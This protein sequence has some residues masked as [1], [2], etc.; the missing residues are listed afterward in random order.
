MIRQI[1]IKIHAENPA[2][3]LPTF[4]IEEYSAATFI[5]EGVPGARG[6]FSIDDITAVVTRADATSQ[7]FGAVKS[8]R[9][10][11][12]TVPAEAFGSSGEIIGGVA[13]FAHGR[14]EN[15]A[16]VESW[17]IGNGD[18]QIFAADGS[19]RPGEKRVE[20]HY[21]AEAPARPSEGDI[22]PINGTWSI[23]NGSRWSA[24]GARDYNG[25]ANK[26]KIEGVTLQ[27]DIHIEDFGAA[28]HN[29]THNINSITGTKELLANKVD[30]ATEAAVRNKTI[31][32]GF[33]RDGDADLIEIDI[34]M[35]RDR[36]RIFDLTF[37]NRTDNFEATYP[38]EVLLNGLKEEMKEAPEGIA[39]GVII[40]TSSSDCR[41]WIPNQVALGGDKTFPYVG[42]AA[43]SV[44]SYGTKYELA[45]QRFIDDDNFDAKILGYTFKIVDEDNVGSTAFEDSINVPKIVALISRIARG[46]ISWFS[47]KNITDKPKINGV[48]LQG[49]LSTEDLDLWGRVGPEKKLDSESAYPDL[50]DTPYDCP[51]GTV[52]S[53]YGKLY[54]KLKEDSNYTNITNGVFW[55]PIR[56][57]DLI[58]EINSRPRLEKTEDGHVAVVIP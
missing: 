50:S 41:I 18:L 31:H 17:A 13:F 29:H 7:A 9:E 27:G 37:R 34:R 40:N 22:A 43:I 52:V 49:N 3:K 12:V 15:G 45:I 23:F 1:N 51:V 6:K 16:E 2:F 58:G 21:F 48:T 4:E 56:I 44:E 53:H 5:L 35:N 38:A 19:I 32:I 10:W 46:A 42:D 20:L 54:R 14:D 11:I 8:G 26:P 57:G 28:K 36:S 25:L 33:N 24:F 39:N 47:Y 55:E 30:V